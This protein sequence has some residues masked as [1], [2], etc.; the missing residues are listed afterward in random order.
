MCSSHKYFCHIPSF[1]L[2][3]NFSALL[4]VLSLALQIPSVSNNPPFNR[5]HLSSPLLSPFFNLIL[6][7]NKS[8]L[9]PQW[10]HSMCLKLLCT[11]QSWPLYHH[12]ASFISL[13]LC[14]AC[15][16]PCSFRLHRWRNKLWWSP[17]FSR[18][19][20][21]VLLH[22]ACLSQSPWAVCQGAFLRLCIS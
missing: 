2:F 12:A 4:F 11:P 17:K 22:T 14:L 10:K 20:V 21:R 7:F 15:R 8:P 19:A 18:W 6:S 9:C 5:Q 1:S 16:K 13:E 3:F